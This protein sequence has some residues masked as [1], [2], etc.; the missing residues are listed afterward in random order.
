MARVTQLFQKL[1]L[2]SVEEEVPQPTE[3]AAAAQPVA[4]PEIPPEKFNGA[5][6]TGGEQISF[7]DIYQR[8]GV[9]APQHGFTI[10]KLIELMAADEFRGLDGAALARMLTGM[11]KRMPGGA[12][13][14]EDIVADAAARDRALDAFERFRAGQLAKLEEKLLNENRD[15]QEEV[16]QIYQRN[17][18]KMAENREQI[19]AEKVA[20]ESWR[21]QKE[22]EEARLFEAV[23]PFVANNPITRGP[24]GAAAPAAGKPGKGA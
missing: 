14:V 1:G 8:A 6:A 11:L 3:L 9:V 15:L 2:V 19:A 20:L 16:D 23:R 24:A 17:N 12:V 13:P 4:V 5:P 18:K 10:D 22:A 21:R 7:A